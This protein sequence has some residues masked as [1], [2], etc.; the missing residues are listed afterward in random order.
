MTNK[1]AS[2]IEKLYGEL[3]E[4]FRRWAEPRSDI[5]AAIL[6][7]S[8]ARVDHLADE[9]SDLD[10]IVIATDP[11]RYLSTSDWINNFGKPLLTFVDTALTGNDRIR[12]VLYEGMLDVDFCIV[13]HEGMQRSSKWIDQ[14]IKANA[15]RKALAWI[16]NVYGRGARVLIDKDGIMG[17]FDAVAASAK[18]PSPPR[19]TH[20]EFI[21]VVNDFFYHAVYTAKHLRRGELWWTVT[22]QNCR[23][24]HSLL[25]MMEWNALAEHGWKHD[26]WLLGRFLEEWA[27]PKAV[28]GLREAFAQYDEEDVKR[29]LLAAIELFQSLALETATKLS[30]P[31]PT[32]TDKN[33]TEWIRTCVAEASN[34]KR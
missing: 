6:V 34:R 13:P 14:T 19:P 22:H 18:K 1:T 16:W 31:Y 28:K 5:R 8:G 20:D 27:T 3:I 10:I 11:E 29:A 26:V 23:L 15:D 21:A 32:E 2:E 17:T 12:V 4:R 30:Y 33:V 9:W 25:Q 24:Q 7:G